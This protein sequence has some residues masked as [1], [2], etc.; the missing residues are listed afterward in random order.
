MVAVFDSKLHFYK[1]AYDKTLLCEFPIENGKISVE[2]NKNK[3]KF[4]NEDNLIGSYVDTTPIFY[5][6]I[7]TLALKGLHVHYINLEKIKE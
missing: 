3:F 5:G 2:F 6:Y 7:G 4:Y 1:T